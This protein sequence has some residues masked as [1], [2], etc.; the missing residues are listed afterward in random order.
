M[1]IPKIP[2]NYDHHLFPE[3]PFDIDI[4][5]GMDANH[6]GKIETALSGSVENKLSGSLTTTNT[7]KLT[8]DAN[9]PVRTDSKLEIMNLPRFTLQ[10]IKDMMK[11]RVRIPNYQTVGFKLMGFELFSICMSGESQIIT[12]PYVPNAAERCEEDPCCA[13]DTRPFPERK[14]HQ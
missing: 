11:N 1:S 4:S 6:S 5:G 9:D 2:Q 8:G 7:L 14:P 3:K 12:E 10:D 13:P